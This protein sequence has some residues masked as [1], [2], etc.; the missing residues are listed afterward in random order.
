MR[1]GQPQSDRVGDEGLSQHRINRRLPKRQ[2]LIFQI[3][4]QLARAARVA[5]L[6]ERLALDLADALARD[7]ELASDKKKAHHQKRRI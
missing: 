7:A 5:Q 3:I 2:G 6:R 4:L 1:K